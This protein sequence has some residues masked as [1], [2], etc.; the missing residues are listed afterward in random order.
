FV[1]RHPEY[2]RL[3]ALSG[4]DESER[5]R[6]MME[7]WR[8]PNVE[9]Y[10]RVTGARTPDPQRLAAIHF[11]FVGAASYVF[12]MPAE[13]RLLFGVDP[14]DGPRPRPPRP[15]HARTAAGAP[16]PEPQ[17]PRGGAAMSSGW[18]GLRSARCRPGRAAAALSPQRVRRVDTRTG[19]RPSRGNVAAEISR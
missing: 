7:T 8:R 15:G 14:G 10:M 4:N 9:L 19:A 2:T 6:W 18:S 1:A 13:S 3:M 5:T 11:A 16:A 12:A 17:A